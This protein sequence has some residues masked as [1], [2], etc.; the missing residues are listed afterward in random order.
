MKLLRGLLC[1]IAAF[2]LPVHAA[3]LLGLVGT[4]SDVPV[5]GEED[6]II[7]NLTGPIFGCSTSVGTPICTA[8]TFDNV[9]LTVDGKPLDL[10]D[11]GPG[12][13]ETYT[14]PDGVFVDGSITSLSLSATLSVT[15]LYDDHGGQYNVSSSFFLNNIAT[16]GSLPVIVAPP[17]VPSSIPEPSSL[18]LLTGLC[19]VG[20]AVVRRSHRSLS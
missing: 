14:F 12:V 19:L 1:G 16:D 4:E 15:T 2:A 9:V 5:A 7:Y 20:G 6:V 10:G 17:A 8:V 13:T 18:A 11:I 3:V